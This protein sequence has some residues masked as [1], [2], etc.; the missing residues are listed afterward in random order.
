MGRSIEMRH[1]RLVAAIAEHGSLTAAARTLGLTQPALSHQLRELETRLRSPLFERTARRMVPTPAGEQLTQIARSVLAQVDVFERQVLDGELSVPRGTVRVAT[2]CYTAY[3]WLPSL[4]REFQGRWPNIEVRVAPEHT[5][6]PL[7]ALRDGGLDLALV[8]RRTADKRI[9]FEPLFDDEL[10]VVTSPEHRFASVKYV[11][12]EAIGDEHLISYTSLSNNSSI[13]RDILQAA[14]VEPAKTTRLQLTEGILE[15]VAAGFGIAILARWA[16]LP[17]VR[18]G[19]V[20]ANRLGKNGYHRAW[21]TAVRSADVIP[22]YQFDLIEIL[23][24][25]LHGGADARIARRLA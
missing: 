11:P 18:S 25:A 8:Y 15:L 20:K 7:A 4:L 21:Y 14:D 16:V 10:V 13:V 19:I 1:L 3:H 6:S 5:A 24:R 17:A 2:E 12:V 22:S 23:R 9:R